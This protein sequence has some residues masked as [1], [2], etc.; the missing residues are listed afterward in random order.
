M[1]GIKLTAPSADFINHTGFFDGQLV[2]IP[3][4][5]ELQIVIVDGFSGFEESSGLLKCHMTVMV[6]TPGAYYGQKYRYNIKAFD[7]D[8]TK[9]DL[10][11][12]NLQVIDAQAGW[13]LV[14]S[15]QELSP[16]FIEQHYSGR[17]FCR[18]RFGLFVSDDGKRMNYIR[19][20]GFDREKMIKVDQ[21]VQQPVQQPAQPVQ[22]QQQQVAQNPVN[23]DPVA[24]TTTAQASP[25]FDTYEDIPF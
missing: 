10:A 11:F 14:R 4:G 20:L 5:E 23:Q 12:R 1:Q 25:K 2:E 6:S 22:P 24:Q 21:P 15:G 16:E 17:A 8:T 13:P 19:G 3:D 9:R 18:A 7:T